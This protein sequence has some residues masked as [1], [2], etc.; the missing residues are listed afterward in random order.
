M[1]L[2]ALKIK[3]CKNKPC[4]FTGGAIRNRSQLRCHKLTM[5]WQMKEKNISQTQHGFQDPHLAQS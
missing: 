3:Q 5:L 1:T 4:V 2:N